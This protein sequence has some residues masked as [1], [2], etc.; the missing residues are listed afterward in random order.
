V[1]RKAKYASDAERQAAYRNRNRVTKCPYC[2]QSFFE[3]TGRVQYFAMLEQ[4]GGRVYFCPTC[5]AYITLQAGQ[6]TMWHV[7]IR[8]NLASIREGRA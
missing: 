7:M 1:G 4:N 2:D 3:V 8:P 5:N 6:P